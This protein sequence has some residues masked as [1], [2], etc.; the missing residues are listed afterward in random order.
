MRGLGFSPALLST[1]KKVSH[2]CE[3]NAR[4][5]TKGVSPRN[6][7]RVIVHTPSDDARRSF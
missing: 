5:Y 1:A 6:L 2:I 7:R 4:D 3:K